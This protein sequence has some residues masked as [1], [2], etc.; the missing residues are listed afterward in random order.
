MPST[1]L[2][3]RLSELSAEWINDTFSSMKNPSW[4]LTL[5]TQAFAQYNALPWPSKND[6]RWKRTELS[7]LDWKNLTFAPSKSSGFNDTV[8]G[9][10]EVLTLPL[11]EALTYYPEMIRAAWTDAI[12]RASNNKFLL[13]TLA[14]GNG[15]TCIFVAPDTTVS[16]DIHHTLSGGQDGHAVFPLNFIVLE[17]NAH[18]Q[19]WDHLGQPTTN[20]AN[21]FVSTYSSVSLAENS[22]LRLFSLQQWDEQVRQFQFCHIRQQAHSRLNSIVVAIGGRLFRNESTIDLSGTGAENKVLGILF[23]DNNQNFENWITQNHWA[24]RTISDIQFR[25]ALKGKAKSFFSGLVSII[26]EAQQSDAYQAAKFLLLSKNA[27]ADAIPNLEILAD[28]VKCS[29]GAAMGPV[30]EEQKFYLQTRGI[31]PDEAEQIIVEGFF[32]PVIDGIPS[33]ETQNQLR[34]F[35]EKKLAS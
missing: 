33:E 19:L 1:T 16:A 23:G 6:P 18:A 15:G 11:E 17:K 22:S 2:S 32:E 20:S 5:R 29:H 3:P 21:T 34:A 14:L 7:A 35:V 13:L 26:K 8:S 9:P 24:R 28:D 30:D 10:P 4:L 27:R 25:G 31:T 12:L